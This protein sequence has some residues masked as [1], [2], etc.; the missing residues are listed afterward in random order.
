MRT[1]DLLRRLASEGALVTSEPAADALARLEEAEALM[2][3]I[4]REQGGACRTCG[5]PFHPATG[6][7]YTERFVV[8]GPCTRAF[9]RWFLPFQKSKGRRKGPAFY[10]HVGLV[11]P[12][13]SSPQP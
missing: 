8:C 5:G 3:R 7:A 9:W 11:A 13:T 6:C 10:D 4:A 12:V 2:D 1:T